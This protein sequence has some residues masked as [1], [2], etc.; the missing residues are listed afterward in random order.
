MS[1]YKKAAVGL[2]FLMM[3]WI[4]F[5]A[6]LFA[7][8]FIQGNKILNIKGEIDIFIDF[9]DKGTE[10]YTILSGERDY[11]KNMVLLGSSA[12]KNMPREFGE[13]LK[14]S[15]DGMAY[16]KGVSAYYLAVYSTK[17]LLNE[18]KTIDR[19]TDGGF[20]TKRISLRW[21][22][23]DYTK[24]GDVYG[25]RTLVGEKD[26]HG[27]IDFTVPK[28]TPVYSAFPTGKVVRVGKNCQ[29][30]HDA[31]KNVDTCDVAKKD[32]YCCCN[33]G[34]GN[35]IVIEHT[36]KGET[37]YTH[38]DHLDEV[39]VNFGYE[40]G[41]DVPSDKP[42]GTSGNTGYVKG[43]TGEHLHFEMGR[44]QYKSDQNSI[45]PCSHF[46]P[47]VPVNCGEKFQ[48]MPDLSVTI[49]LPNGERGWLEMII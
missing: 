44:S 36:S 29:P 34:L 17:G 2:L 31:C 26:F 3:L 4:T 8:K 35:F 28:G 39:F 14:E 22:V 32:S 45:N 10:L 49:P 21:P 25:W 33:N 41:K 48:M 6:L 1:K 47:P 16:L 11:T 27:G 43:V 46:P 30:S 42:I 40:I 20:I 38:Y 15:L 19:P 13:R 12:A 37:F 18:F 24:I 23:V 7:I 5:F 9:N